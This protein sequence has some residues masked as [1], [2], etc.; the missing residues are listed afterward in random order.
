[1]TTVP[2]PVPFEG[3]AFAAPV[4]VARARWN[5]P[6]HDDA[7]L[8]ARPEVLPGL[9]REQVWECGARGPRATDTLARAAAYPVPSD[10]AAR[11]IPGTKVT[12]LRKGETQ[13]GAPTAGILQGS[14]FL[15]WRGGLGL[16][17]T[18]KRRDGVALTGV[19]DL[20]EGTAPAAVEELA[21]RWYV[22]TELPPTTELKREALDGVSETSPLAVLWTHPGFGGG[23]VPGCVWFIDYVED[24]IGGGYCWCPE[25]ELVSEHGSFDLTDLLG[26]AALVLAP[27]A[28]DFGQCLTLP[29]DTREAYRVLFGR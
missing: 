26:S 27:P 14:I 24:E 10:L 22:S 20:I 13:L 19:L 2:I 23:P 28:V 12:V 29:A 11:L 25:S 9:G 8:L 3:D 4:K 1:M 18:G 21:A 7:V 17:P 15:G 16:M 5:L 6:V